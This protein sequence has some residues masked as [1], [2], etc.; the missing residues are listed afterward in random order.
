MHDGHRKRLKS[1]FIKEGLDSFEPHQILELLLFYSIPRKDTNPIA[2][3]LINKF[4]SLSG[5]FEASVADLAATE[6]IG[7]NTAILLSLIPSISRKYFSDKWRE[8]TVIDG[9]EKAGQYM[10]SLFTG[11]QYEC[12]YLISLDNQNRVISSTLVHEGTINESAVYPRIIVETALRHQAS[13]VL[14]AHN[15]PGGSTKPSNADILV[16]KKIVSALET[17]DIPVIDHIIVAGNVYV[18]FAE[19]GLI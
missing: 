14:I 13:K 10:I 4:H 18:S 8:K 17:I 16:T 1:R 7:E 9:S 12:F 15:H 11:R 2:H 5:V 6:G 3:N 19:K